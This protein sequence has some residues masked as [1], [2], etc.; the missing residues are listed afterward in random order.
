MNKIDL[1]MGVITKEYEAAAKKLILE[2]FR[3]RF[4]FIDYSLNPYLNC[5]TEAYGHEGSLFLISLAGKELV[6]TGALS[7]EGDLTCRIE[8]MSV[9]KE[10]RSKGL[11]RLMVKELENRARSEGYTKIAIETNSAWNSAVGLY[12]SSGYKEYG[13]EGGMIHFYKMI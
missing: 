1:K 11:A 6:C 10:F 4:G 7:K 12:K 9:K 13:M 3:E 5:I 8:R 2:G